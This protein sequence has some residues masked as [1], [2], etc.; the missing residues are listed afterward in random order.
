MPNTREQLH[1]QLIAQFR[2]M[3]IEVPSPTTDLIEEGILDS[4]TF[5]ELVFRLESQ[6]GVKVPIETLDT[7]DFRTVDSIANVVT[8]TKAA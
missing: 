6:F 1:D 3:Q 2:D 5:V 4:M 7:D 8:R